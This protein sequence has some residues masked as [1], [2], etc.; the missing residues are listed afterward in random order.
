MGPC[1]DTPIRY[2][3]Q[4]NGLLHLEAKKALPS[5]AGGLEALLRSDEEAAHYYQSLPG[6]IQDTLRNS[7]ARIDSADELRRQAENAMECM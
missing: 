7:G 4:Q 1:P 5:P 3:I 6:Y 2:T